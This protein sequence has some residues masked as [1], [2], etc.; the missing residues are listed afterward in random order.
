MKYCK[1]H[2]SIPE[3]D[4]LLFQKANLL[5]DSSKGKGCGRLSKAVD[6]AEAGYLFRVRIDVQRIAHDTAPA[7]IPGKQGDLTVGC[8]LAARNPA[9]HVV[10]SFKRVFHHL[11]LSKTGSASAR[12]ILFDVRPVSA[13]SI[14]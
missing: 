6:D 9:H 3:L 4:A 14:G 7:R 11:T 13:R 1:I 12:S 10:D 5:V 2:A 8:N